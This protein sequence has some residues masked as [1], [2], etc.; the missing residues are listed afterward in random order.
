MVAATGEND[1]LLLFRD[2]ELEEEEEKMRRE[3]LPAQVCTGE[4]EDDGQ[5]AS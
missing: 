4:Q 5:Y 3:V 2:E 1:A